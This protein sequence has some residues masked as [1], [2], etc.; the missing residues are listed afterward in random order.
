MVER[1]RR[2][3][4]ATTGNA[5]CII[6]GTQQLSRIRLR[7]DK[8]LHRAAP[9]RP[10]KITLSLKYITCV[11]SSNFDLRTTYTKHQTTYSSRTLRSTT[12]SA[13]AN[14]RLLRIPDHMSTVC[15]KIRSK[16][17]LS[18]SAH[19]VSSN[20]VIIGHWGLISYCV[21]QHSI[22]LTRTQK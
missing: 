18:K 1:P 4:T 12:A 16:L 19:R 15:H 8:F 2:P 20:A 14:A 6:S 5:Y 22:R 17:E 13:N 9:G 21:L 10:R 7:A 11:P 3:V